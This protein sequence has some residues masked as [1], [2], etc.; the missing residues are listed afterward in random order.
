[1]LRHIL[2]DLELAFIFIIFILV[3]WIVISLTT[4]K[5]VIANIPGLQAKITETDIA[6]GRDHC[7]AEQVL[8]Y[9][10]PLGQL[11]TIHQQ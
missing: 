11:T 4:I 10:N 5:P 8:T 3:L 9:E 6:P 1:M 2:H 7:R